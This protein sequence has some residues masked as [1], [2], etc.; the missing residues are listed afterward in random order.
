MAQH[1]LELRGGEAGIQRDEHDTE[2]G[3]REHRDHELGP[4]RKHQRDPVALLYA[5]VAEGSGERPSLALY[6]AEAQTIFIEDEEHVFGIGSG[7][8]FE[9]GCDGHA[10][11]AL[12][13]RHGTSRCT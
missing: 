1:V 8:L 3:S 12:R 2:L 5:K 11:R 4:A 10:L 6:L 9:R 7:S 13:E